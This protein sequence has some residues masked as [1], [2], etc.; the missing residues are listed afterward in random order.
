MMYSLKDTFVSLFTFQDSSISKLT[1]EIEALKKELRERD[2]ELN[3]MTI[4]VG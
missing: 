4:K 1:R 2:S 3:T